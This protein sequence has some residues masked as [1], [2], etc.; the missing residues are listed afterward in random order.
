MRVLMIDVSSE[1]GGAGRSFQELV[2]T[3]KKQYPNIEPV[4]L[5]SHKHGHIDKFKDNGIEAYPTL[6]EA[7]NYSRDSKTLVYLAKIF[8]RFVRYIICDIYALIYLEKNVDM[9]SIDL[10]HTNSIRNDIGMILAKKYQIPHILHLREFGSKGLDYDV[11]YF[12]CKPIQYVDERVNRY[13]AIT[14]AVKNYWVNVN[15]INKS[16]ISIVYNGI[17]DTD[18]KVRNKRCK[19][20]PMRIVMTGYFCKAK[21]QDELVRALT[22]L[23]CY[24]LKNIHVDFIGNGDND[25]IN[26]IKKIIYG[27]NL[28]NV[29]SFLGKQDNVHK[30]LWQ[31]DIGVT[32]SRAEAFG[33]VTAEYMLA[34]LCVIASNTGGNLELIKNNVTGLLYKY[35]N[36]QSLTEEI[37][38]LYNDYRLLETLANNGNKFAKSNFVTQKNVAGIVNVYRQVLEY[39]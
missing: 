3:L 39:K 6:H 16:K 35:G 30:R 13:I 27:N 36:P 31:Y 19:H 32:C 17:D 38:G 1:D 7:F 26:S 28:Q 10:I 23:P 15:K 14:S 12:R 11:R 24:I 18:I 37:V 21:G 2:I 29:V 22:Y 33:R 4:V 5:C 34:G 9:K 25:Y 20:L 8:P